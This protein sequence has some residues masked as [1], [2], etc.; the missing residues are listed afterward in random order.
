LYW[1]SLLYPE[2]TLAIIDSATTLGGV[3]AEHRL[4]IELRTNN[5][6][7]TYKYPGSLINNKALV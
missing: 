3:W 4:Y 6:L 5:M 7:G 2:E 1:E